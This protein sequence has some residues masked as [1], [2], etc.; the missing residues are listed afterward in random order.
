MK[1]LV[2]TKGLLWKL[3]GDPVRWMEV[4]VPLRVPPR[5]IFRRTEGECEVVADFRGM[6]PLRRSQKEDPIH[7]R[8]PL[9][10]WYAGWG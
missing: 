9:P 1:T 8:P 10:D 6:V 7:A 2:F 3:R 4:G 5:P